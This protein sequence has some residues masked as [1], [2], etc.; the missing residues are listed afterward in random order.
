MKWWKTQQHQ[1][2]CESFVIEKLHPMGKTLSGSI[3]LHMHA[4]TVGSGILN[5][6]RNLSLRV[7]SGSSL[8]II[9]PW[10]KPQQNFQLHEHFTSN[11]QQ[12][13][14]LLSSVH[15]THTMMEH[16]Q[17][18]NLLGPLG[19]CSIYTDNSKIRRF[20]FTLNLDIV[21]NQNTDPRKTLKFMQQHSNGNMWPC[22]NTS[23]PRSTTIIFCLEY[24]HKAVLWCQISEKN[25]KQQ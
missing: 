18:S 15:I 23:N 4:R 21:G 25:Q 5:S 24:L 8:W 12:S 17:N 13:L 6:M 14:Q 9:L 22:W 10:S 16:A 3:F 19:S 7:S 20:Q 2:I 1:H 11:L